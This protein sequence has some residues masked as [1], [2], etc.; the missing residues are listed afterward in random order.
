MLGKY[1]EGTIYAIVEASGKQYRVAAGDV[2][3]L[4]MP[5]QKGDTLELDRVLMVADGEDI[6][7]GAPTVPGASVVGSVIEVGKGKKIDVRK[8]KA[9]VHYHKKTGHRQSYTRMEIKEIKLA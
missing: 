3:D 4:D 7:V 5:A 1:E 6:K 2:I 8:F 9:K